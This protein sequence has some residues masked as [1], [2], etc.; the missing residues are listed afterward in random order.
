MYGRQRAP[1]RG[2]RGPRAGRRPP[3][4]ASSHATP[5]VAEVLADPHGQV[6]RPATSAVPG[7]TLR[8][9]RT[10][11][12]QA[13]SSVVERLE[14]QHLDRAAGRLGE[15][16]PGRQH[17]GRVDH[18][19]VARARPG[20][21]VGHVPVRGAA[22]PGPRRPAGGPRRGARPASGRSAAGQLVVEGG[23][24]HGPDQCPRPCRE[25][26]PGGAEG[27]QP[28]QAGE[29]RSSPDACAGRPA[30]PRWARRPA[31]ATR[32][33]GVRMSRPCWMRKGS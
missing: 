28:K 33:R 17:P 26:A 9:G 12:S 21:Q 5:T 22:D 31:V 19:H 25:R 10:R 20:G 3:R 8:L 2:G 14:Q 13:G 24:V 18:D 15:P 30:R 32:P 7:G 16:Q 27:A 1:R 4:A 11:A 6:R 29:R 23:G